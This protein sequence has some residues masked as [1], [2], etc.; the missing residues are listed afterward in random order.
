MFLLRPLLIEILRLL[1]MFHSVLV[2]GVLGETV[3][4]D[5]DGGRGRSE[6]LRQRRQGGQIG[7]YSVRSREPLILSREKKRSLHCVSIGVSSWLL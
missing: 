2:Q 7:N 1:L 3:V 4:W 6:E 5:V